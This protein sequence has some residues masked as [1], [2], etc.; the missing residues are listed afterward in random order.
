MKKVF[1]FM[2]Q[3]NDD[4]LQWIL[5]NGKKERI[6]KNDVL[7]EQ[8]EPVD[9]LFIVLDGKFNIIFNFAKIAELSSGEI[10]GEMSFVDSNPPIAS[11][12]AVQKSHVVSIKKDLINKKIKEDTGFAS[13]F[14]YALSL[15]LVDRLRTNIQ[16][17]GYS[18]ASG[19]Q[20]H[21]HDDSEIDPLILE[22]LT[23]AGERFQ[24]ILHKFK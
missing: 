6:E 7:I 4:D 16:I 15:F 5:K 9:K 24:R 20:H 14:F 10:I 17:L 2:G 21:M 13:R 1:Y 22:N 18:N 23:A 8:Y 19:T 3:L 12:V 11:V